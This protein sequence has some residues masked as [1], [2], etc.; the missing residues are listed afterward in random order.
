MIMAKS[1]KK[2]TAV[3]Q[4]NAVGHTY[5]SEAMITKVFGVNDQVL[6]NSGTKQLPMNMFE[7]ESNAGLIIP[8]LYDPLTWAFTLEQSTRLNKLV[9][10][11]AVNTVGLGWKITPKKDDESFRTQN[12]D[13][14]KEEREE[15]EEVFEN[16]NP[17]L[18]FTEIM[19]QVKID[20]ES[21]GQGYIETV[22][23]RKGIKVVRVN[24][25][26]SYTIRVATFTKDRPR[27]IRFVQQ[28][29][30][31]GNR[32]LRVYF[33]E[34]NEKWDL[35]M[36]T[37][38]WF[39]P[40]TL[41]E[42]DS[43]NELI[44]FKL[45]SPRS[46][47]YGVPRAVSTA[48]AIAGTR[49]AHRRNVAFFE[50][51]ACPRLAVIVNGGTLT[52]EAMQSIE[53]F[54]E[55]RAKGPGNAGRLM[56][57]QGKVES[58]LMG[59]AGSVKIQLMPLTVGVQDDASFT[60]YTNANNE[61]IR[62]AFGIGQIFI[63]TS[64]N[65]NRAVAL[66]MKQ[67]TVEQIFKPESVRYEYI[68]N[69]TIVKTYDVKHTKLTFE[70]AKTVDMVGESQALTMLASA[71]GV[72]PNDIRDFMEKP[73]YNAAWGDTPLNVQRLGLLE[74]KTDA[75]STISDVY[76]EKLLEGGAVDD[77]GAETDDGSKSGKDTK[78]TSTA[79]NKDA[80]EADPTEASQKFIAM[81]RRSTPDDTHGA[82]QD[83]KDVL[84]A[85]GIDTSITYSVENE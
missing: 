56:V 16:I 26:P 40:G 39:P 44:Q 30:T 20:E 34:F 25:V 81:D 10:S 52:E 71:A 29:H 38:E 47:Y 24:H 57:L 73:R 13:K 27:S 54:I 50:N 9:R 32:N 3:V 46:S 42:E 19:S 51:D 80:K 48:P 77:D 4:V 7:K 33:K 65:V 35:H 83:L 43:A 11:M 21:T 41:P 18:P 82:L 49:L 74:S 22:R 78:G 37:G 2:S 84:E 36:R 5:E 60:K 76:G 1:K 6:D 70:K 85:Q 66:A 53:D 64:D 8:P 17:D 45:Y 61:E 68:L 31:G 62:E 58:K 23:D 14:I 28:R 67:L 59:D 75:T 15:L 12:L 72:T 55:S 79:G 63:G 69:Q